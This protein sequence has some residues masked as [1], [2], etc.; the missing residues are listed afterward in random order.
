MLAG[1]VITGGWLSVTVTV[2]EQEVVW[3]LAAVTV[4]VL[5]VVPTGKAAP[6]ARPAVCA[7]VW[8]G[9]LSV[10]TGVVYVATALHWPASLFTA[11]LAGQ[12]IIGG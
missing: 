8:P 12:V 9:Q 7:V 6:E 2:N 4:N 3:L 1:Q 5:V 11:M 10:P